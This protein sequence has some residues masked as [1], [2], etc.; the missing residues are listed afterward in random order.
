ME[1]LK[2]CGRAVAAGLL[3]AAVVAVVVPSLVF[4]LNAIALPAP[5]ERLAA[6]IRTAFLSGA[7]PERDVHEPDRR[8][9]GLSWND[10]L[11]LMMAFDHGRPRIENA[12]SPMILAPRGGGTA[13]GGDGACSILHDVVMKGAADRYEPRPYHRY[14]SGFAAPAALAVPALGVEGWRGL[15]RAANYAAILAILAILAA[16]PLRLAR[17]SAQSPAR[18][19]RMSAGA[20]LFAMILVFG[21]VEFYA[22]GFGIG[23]A[24]LV[25]YGLMAWLLF[26]EPLR[27]PRARFVAVTA[28]FFGWITAFEF[29][30][31]QIPLALAAGVGLLGLAVETEED[32]GVLRSRIFDFVATG[33]LVV[34]G[35]LAFKVGAATLVFG[36]AV[37]AEFSRQ[38]AVRVGDGG[39]GPFKLL[40]H[41]AGRADHVGQGSLI[42]GLLNGA[43]ATAALFTGARMLVAARRLDPARRATAL[44]L[45]ASLILLLVWH[46]VFRNH[47]TIHSEFM[48]RSFVWWNAAGWI[49]LMLGFEIRRAPAQAPEPPPPPDREPL[50]KTRRS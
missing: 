30:T 31:G 37:P 15:L 38:L 10:C 42:L 48:V 29:W 3:A 11:I 34:L 17:S 14:V 8:I 7:L 4:G 6:E 33:S 21:G 2:D 27:M 45:A 13:T 26:G 1:L 16:A 19:R 12:V 24:D 43:L 47:S 23:L 41:L 49:V 36:P 32:A 18:R 20:V 5:P 50:P 22:Q 35:V 25:V 9:G 39:Y 40:L 44:A 28:F 46:L